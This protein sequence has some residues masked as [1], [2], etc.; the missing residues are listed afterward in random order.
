MK[1]DIIYLMWVEHQWRGFQGQRSTVKVKV[2]SKCTFAAKAC[3]S[4]VWRR[5]SL[6]WTWTWLLIIMKNQSAF[7][8][9][10]AKRMQKFEVKFGLYLSSELNSVSA[11]PRRWSYVCIYYCVCIFVCVSV[12]VC[13]C[14]CINC[15]QC[16]MK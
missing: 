11:P 4:T 2:K 15:Y 10:W 13:M 3:I 16:L 1:L 8:V 7:R 6:V 9:L 12:Y 14:L 5:D